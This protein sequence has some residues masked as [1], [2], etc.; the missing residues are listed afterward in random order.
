[1]ALVKNSRAGVKGFAQGGI[2]KEC[3]AV[4]HDTGIAVGT[5]I[6]IAPALW[7]ENYRV[8]WQI[9]EGTGRQP[10]WSFEF[11]A[12]PG[13]YPAS[14][15]NID[16]KYKNVIVKIRVFSNKLF[17]VY[18]EYLALADMHDFLTYHN[19]QPLQLWTRQSVDNKKLNVYNSANRI[20]GLRVSLSTTEYFQSEAFVQGKP[21]QFVNYPS[22]DNR[23]YLEVNDKVTNGFILGEDLKVNLR[24]FPRYTNSQY[25]CGIFRV[26]ELLNQNLSFDDEILLQYALANNTADE[27]FTLVTNFIARNRLKDVHGFRYDNFE[28]VADFTIDKDYFVNGGR[29]RCFIV[30]KESCQFRSYLFDEFGV[31]E[32]RDIPQG[33]IDVDSIDIDGTS[34]NIA[35][36]SCLYDVPSDCEMVVNMKMDMASYEANLVLLGLI[37]TWQDYF[38]EAYCFVSEGV[39]QTGTNP[40]LDSVTYTESG[41]DAIIEWTFKIPTSWEGTNKFLNFVWVFDYKN[42]YVD[43]VVG[44]T[45]LQVHVTDQTDIELKGTPPPDEICDVDAQELEFCFENPSV[46]HQFE[47]DLLKDNVKSTEELVLNKEANFA[48]NADGC[49]DF[50]YENASSEVLYCAELR[51]HDQTVS[52]GPPPCDDLTL[53]YFDAGNNQFGFC[54]DFASWINTD[55]YYINFAF[56]DEN[57]SYEWYDTANACVQV[58]KFTNRPTRFVIYILRVDGFSYNLSGYLQT[59]SPLNELTIETCTSVVSAYCPN[60]PILSHTISWNFNA[61][62]QLPNKTVTPIFTNPGAPTSQTKQYRLNGGAWLNYTVPLTISPS[63]KVEFLWTLV[64]GTTCTIELYDCLTEEECAFP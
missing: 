14:L 1:M 23:Y 54:F 3:V 22:T 17:I 25:Y 35:A 43:H 11:T 26:D 10:V 63:W 49:F 34:I 15:I 6:Y 27:P 31:N 30:C 51:A 56:I 62:G 29:Y 32:K 57:V 58:Q 24:N 59:S 2:Y 18:L 48:T 20:M 4:S 8:K 44:Y 50:D 16:S 46:S 33:T 53:T 52:A 9:D 13:T 41:G 47:L 45:S 60:N 38:K 19:Y 39:H 5:K 21:W 40:F 28:S 7:D 55:I 36:G 12:I 61:G 42:G 64:Y 37:G